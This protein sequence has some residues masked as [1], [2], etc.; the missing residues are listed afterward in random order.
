MIGG[1]KA[2][3]RG[4]V[5]YRWATVGHQPVTSDRVSLRAT[6]P[7]PVFPDK[8]QRP[9]DRKAN[10]GAD[11]GGFDDDPHE[12]EEP[13]RGI[14]PPN[15]AH[16]EQPVLRAAQERGEDSAGDGHPGGEIVPPEAVVRLRTPLQC[17]EET[18]RKD[19]S[20]AVARTTKCTGR[21]RMLPDGV[22]DV[23]E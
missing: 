8:A 10:D 1:S 12:R 3:S 18:H 7:V 11:A 5:I 22:N 14:E 15:A 17:R 6:A 2:G 21:S 9:A 23:D 19:V 16:D 20:G 13:T 4:I